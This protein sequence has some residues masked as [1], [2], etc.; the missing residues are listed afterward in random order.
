MLCAGVTTYKGLKETE[1]KPGQFVAI[2][3]AA[4]G[5][6][7]LAVQYAKAM[8]MRVVAIDVGKEKLD[9]VKRLGA[10]FAFDA[11]APDVIDQVLNLTG[12]GTHGVLC[13]ATNKAAFNTAVKITRRKGTAVLVGLPNSTFEVPIVEIV[14]KRVTIRGSIV[15][16]R[17]D[18]AEALDFAAR[19]LVKCDIH[20]DKID[21]INTIVDNLRVGKIQGRTVIEFLKDPVKH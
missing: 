16:T 8:G 20:V 1:T 12:G 10:E 19:G 3:G 7:H 21:N 18:M 11:T 4:G 17:Q 2:L 15:G 14:L 9:Y 5:L 6:G 13:L